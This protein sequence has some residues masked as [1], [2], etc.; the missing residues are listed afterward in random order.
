[1]IEKHQ[2]AN[3]SLKE[4]FGGKKPLIENSNPILSNRP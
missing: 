3:L 2:V 4:I 1:M